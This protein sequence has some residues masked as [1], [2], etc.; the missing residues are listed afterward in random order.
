MKMLIVDDDF[1]NRR[2]LQKIMAPYGEIDHASDGVDAMA[3]FTMS[4]E[5]KDPYDL[6][7]LDIFMPD[8]D[9]LEA[10]KMIRDLEVLNNV[11]PNKGVKIIMVT[12]SEKA[13]HIMTAFRDGCESYI[14]KPITKKG[15]LAEVLKLGLI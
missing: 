5:E 14:N 4:L 1:C 12:T 13:D 9:G 8:I 2:L 7:L 10:L 11:A 6:I 15:I 3:A